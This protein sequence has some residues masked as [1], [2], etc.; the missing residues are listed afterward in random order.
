[1][2]KNPLPRRF[3]LVAI[4]GCAAFLVF[5]RRVTADITYNLVS[6]PLY[7]NGYD[8]TGTI[9]TDGATGTISTSDI[10]SIEIPPPFSDSAS[11]PLQAYSSTGT[12][13]ATPTALI[14]PPETYLNIED[15]QTYDNWIAWS[16]QA[17]G[18]YYLA[19]SRGAELWIDHSDGQLIGALPPSFLPGTD[20]V[21]ATAVPEPSTVVLLG[22]VAIS[23]LAC[24]WRRRA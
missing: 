7:Q 17:S 3:V 20:W 23:L 11:D 21:V 6:Y 8:V 5:A 15:M 10:R 4:V 14:V 9:T 24:A 18:Y 16:N 13:Y 22:I 1:M 2:S 19:F 12:L